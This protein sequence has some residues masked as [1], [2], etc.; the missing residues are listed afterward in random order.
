MLRF[1]LGD[2]NF[3]Q[4]LQNYLNDPLLAY[5][6]AKTPNMQAHLE[7]SSGLNLTEFFNDWVYN[8]GYPVYNIEAHNIG[9]GQARITINQSQ[10]DPSVSFFE[11]PIPIRLFGSGGLQQDFILDNTTNGQQFIVNV[12]FTVTSVTFDPKKDIISRNGSAVL[13]ATSFDL[14]S[15]VVLYPNPANSIITIETPNLYILQN[16]IIYNALGQKVGE[17]NSNKIPVS[18]FSNGMYSVKII[19]SEGAIL[20]K[21]I[22]K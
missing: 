12:P 9:N 21:F 20:K 7:A 3:F 5:G 19:T 18:Q 8:Q 13:A 15:S 4:G 10:S 16:I 14:S 6:Y 17:F 22:K 2:A 11:M 1:K